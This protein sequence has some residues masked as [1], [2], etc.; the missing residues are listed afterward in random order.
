MH[1]ML[2]SCLQEDGGLYLII[3]NEIQ[4]I[5]KGDC[6]GL[7]RID[8]YWYSLE[9]QTADKYCGR[10]H[11]YDKELYK[12][13]V[14]TYSELGDA[15]DLKYMNG[16]IYAVSSDDQRVNQIFVIDA[17]SMELIDKV[18]T[19][20]SHLNSVCVDNN[21]NVYGAIH[22]W[23][24]K[25]DRQYPQ[26]KIL[27]FTDYFETRQ[28]LNIYPVINNLWHPHDCDYRNGKY[29][30]LDSLHGKI[31]KWSPVT[32]D[33]INEINIGCYIRG[34][35]F[36]DN[37]YYIGA[38]MQRREYTNTNIKWFE[39]NSVLHVNRDGEILDKLVIP[40]SREVYEIC[41]IHY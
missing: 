17:N 31:L 34:F 18:P 27:N 11:I 10:I 8:E 3:D 28:I 35:D 23:R 21:G 25:H 40:Y 30:V 32:K 26:G 5:Y 12:L 22:F 20:I 13:D 38:S 36:E 24:Q 6:T 2:V 41:L 9:R 15:H 1:D 16:Y 7:D 14:Y 19:E 4:I 37:D 39:Q 29:Y 33:I